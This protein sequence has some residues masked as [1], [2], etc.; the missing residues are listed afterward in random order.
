[1]DV[2]T[3]RK[4]VAD[5]APVDT[6][7]LSLRGHETQDVGSFI[8]TRYKT[9]L[10][11]YIVYQEKGFTHYLSGE[12]ITVNQGFISV[13]TIGALNQ[14]AAFESAGKSGG[15]TQHHSKAGKKRKNKIMQM[16]GAVS[17]N[18]R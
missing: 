14:V 4:V 16:V 17:K 10:L 13:D 7:M 15:Y 18:K 9:Q 2:K 3:Q 12:F 1:M 6:G 8:L 11:P 5:N